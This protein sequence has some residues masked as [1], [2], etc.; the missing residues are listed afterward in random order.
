[1]GVV[2]FARGVARRGGGERYRARGRE[3]CQSGF[4][5]RVNLR[6][7]NAVPWLHGDDRHA[8][9]APLLTGNADHGRFGN[10]VKL[11]KHVLD[12][13]RID[14]LAA[15]NVHVLPA[16][17]D[18]VKTFLVDPRGIAGMQP[19]VGEGRLVGV[20]LVPVT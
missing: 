17:D 2:E 11:V 14:V 19:A 10:S 8:G 15:G 20:G 3:A 12:F 18:V 16:I 1:G 5:V 7:V 4:A 9:F 6:L 13:G